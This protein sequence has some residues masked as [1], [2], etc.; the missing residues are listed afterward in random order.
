MPARGDAGEG[1][2]DAMAFQHRL[3]AQQQA[4]QGPGDIAKADK[5]QFVLH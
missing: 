2:R 4:D 3:F 5:C 1:K